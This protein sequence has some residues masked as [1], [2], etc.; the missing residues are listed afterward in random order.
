MVRPCH[1]HR[2]GGGSSASPSSGVQRLPPL[3]PSRGRL[4]TRSMSSFLDVAVQR[5]TA[6]TRDSNDDSAGWGAKGV[7]GSFSQLPEALQR[8]LELAT[9]S[10]TAHLNAPDTRSRTC[11]ARRSPIERWRRGW[12]GVHLVHDHRQLRRRTS[13]WTN[14]RHNAFRARATDLRTYFID[15]LRRALGASGR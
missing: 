1:G 12:L 13:V 14:G 15:I 6:G 9:R 10:P 2:H 4:D 3:Y 5:P 8:L 7:G 11:R